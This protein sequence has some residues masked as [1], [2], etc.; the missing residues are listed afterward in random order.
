V[1]PYGAF[2]RVTTG[3]EGL[4]H[5]SRSLRGASQARRRW[6]TPAILC[7]SEWLRSTPSDVGCRCRSVKRQEMSCTQLGQGKMRTY[8]RDKMLDAAIY[9]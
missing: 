7:V 9:L 5:I 8:N 6:F 4:I 1:M 3:I 2:A